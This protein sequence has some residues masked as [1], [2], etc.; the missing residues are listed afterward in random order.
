MVCPNQPGTISSTFRIRGC[1]MGLGR[2]NATVIPRSLTVWTPA[3][4][5]RPMNATRVFAGATSY[6]PHAAISSWNL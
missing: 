6:G 4:R 3:N 2:A 5:T 1:G